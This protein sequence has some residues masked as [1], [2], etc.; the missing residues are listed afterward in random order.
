MNI[1]I[2][3]LEAKAEILRAAAHPLRLA[4]LLLLQKEKECTV[5]QIYKTLQIEQAVA[6]HHLRI[7]KTHQLVV[8]RKSGKNAFY[9]LNQ[10]TA[11]ALLKA[12]DKI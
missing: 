6:S 2:N 1:N 12:I 9:S 3:I 11:K 7:L 5:S 8:L 4:I 10:A